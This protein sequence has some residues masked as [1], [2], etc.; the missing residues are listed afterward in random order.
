[1]D[2]MRWCRC[3][4]AMQRACSG[5]RW[6][7]LELAISLEEPSS[8]PAHAGCTGAKRKGERASSKVP[9][10]Q[11][12]AGVVNRAQKYDRK[13]KRW[14]EVTDALTYCLAKDMLSLHT[15]DKRGFRRMVEALNLRY[16]LPSTKYLSKT[17]IPT[18]Y[19]QTRAKVAAEVRSAEFFAATLD[20]WSSMTSEPYLSYT[21]QT[22]VGAAHVVPPNPLS[23]AGSHR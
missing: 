9:D 7:H 12:L 6:E 19:V 15:V 22:G 3:L 8:C 21:V 13:T 10:S 11:T 1:M 14:R 4:S 23:P 5:A 20:L 16:D 2:D 17:A 18:L